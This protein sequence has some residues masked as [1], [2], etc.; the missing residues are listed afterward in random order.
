MFW[1]FVLAN[2]PYIMQLHSGLYIYTRI[3]TYMQMCIDLHVF[4]GIYIAN[5]QAHL[6]GLWFE[7]RQTLPTLRENQNSCFVRK[8]E[9][10]MCTY[11]E[12]DIVAFFPQIKNLAN[13]LLDL[14]STEPKYLWQIPLV[15]PQLDR[16]QTRSKE[17]KMWGTSNGRIC[18]DS[19]HGFSVVPHYIVAVWIDA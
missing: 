9:V 19:S 16:C 8:S 12:W 3:H 17:A 7:T 11:K 6:S 2:L 5:V 10:T 15:I 14:C 13:K 1:V 4:T 18:L